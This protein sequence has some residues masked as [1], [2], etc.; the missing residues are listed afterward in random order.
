MGGERAEPAVRRIPPA[1]NG[2]RLNRGPPSIF[3]RKGVLP[4]GIFRVTGLA[5]T[6]RHRLDVVR[7]ACAP[8]Q[9]RRPGHATV[10]QDDSAAD[11]RMERTV[12]A[13]FR[14]VAAHILVRATQRCADRAT[15]PEE[16]GNLYGASVSPHL[17]SA[18]ARSC[19]RRV[20]SQCGIS[21]ATRA[22]LRVVRA[23]SRWQVWKRRVR[24]AIA[25]VAGAAVSVSSPH[26]SATA[27]DRAPARA[28][29]SPVSM[30]SQVSTGRSASVPLT[31]S[32]PA[33]GPFSS[34]IT[35]TAS[36]RSAA[37]VRASVRTEGARRAPRP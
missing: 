32:A 8:P 20:L 34:S 37:R 31:V 5:G 17:A 28:N 12:P 4:D 18:Q 7:L 27:A 19:R 10:C 25:V 30:R 1:G 36:P 13:H 23:V 9:S 15:A 11:P 29:W 6:R 14:C 2:H 33:T 22:F 26:H 3:I 21:G 16:K 24:A 35:D